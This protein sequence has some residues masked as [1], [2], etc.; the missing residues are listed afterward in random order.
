MIRVYVEGVPVDALVDTGAALSVMN[1]HLCSR[2]K[3]VMTPYDGLTLVA[4]EGNTIR[5]SAF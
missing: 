2:L 5:P 1:A 4:A 3:K